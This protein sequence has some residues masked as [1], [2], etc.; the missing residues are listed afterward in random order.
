MT[1]VPVSASEP[2]RRR[3]HLILFLTAIFFFNF[4]ARFIWGPLLPAIEKDLGILHAASG[5]LFLMMSFG[6]GIG[7]F[8]SGV[9]SSRITHKWTVVLS[10]L[11]VSLALAAATLAPSL[12]ML[13]L[14]LITV[15]A[16]AGLYLPSAIASL[17][18]RLEPRH[19]GKAFSFHEVSPSLGFV[20]GPLLVEALLADCSWRGVLWPVAGAM[21]VMGL[22]YAVG[23][24]TGEYR[25]EAPNLKNVRFVLTQKTFWI[26]LGLYVLMVGMNVGVYSMLPLYL[27]SVRGFSQTMTNSVLAASRVAAMF[28]PFLAGWA[29]DRYGPAPVLAI[30]ISTCGLATALIGLVPGHWVWVMIFLQSILSVA[31]FPPGFAIL[32]GIVPP[33]QRNLIVA[34]LMP[35]AMLLGSGAMPTLIGVFGDSGRFA[36]GF[37]LFGLLTTFSTL[38]LWFL[39]TA[40]PE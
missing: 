36:H 38:L 2:F 27:Q 19:W 24:G 10:S 20:V 35:V 7:L 11:A 9:F 26:M 16:S 31:F 6:Y 25:G 32:A 21:L 12:L 30:I 37:I 34:L 39:K 15:G 3:L 5:S 18:W 29:N 1:A 22:A 8:M 28:T 4:L 23:P 33:S 17:T 40:R 14:I 13:R